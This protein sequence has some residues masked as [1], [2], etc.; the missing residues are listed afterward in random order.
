[1]RVLYIDYN[2]YGKNDIVKA[3]Q[4]LGYETEITD[5]PLVYGE[6]TE[7]TDNAVF[8]KIRNGSYDMV[9][10]SNYYPAVSDSCER[11]GVT[12][13][14]W[15]YDS[16]RIALYDSTILNK[17]NHAFTFD[18]SECAKLRNKG[19]E[20]IYYMPLATAAER[21]DEISVTEDD[22][23][24]FGADV[25]LVASLYNE[26]HNLYDR[27]EGR[28]DG[29]TRG[30]LLGL[31]NAQMN[32]F[33]SNILEDV[34]EGS[35]PLEKMYEAMPYPIKEGSLA[36]LEYIYS[37]YF[38]CR[39]VATMQR[40]GMIK[41]ISDSF[42]MKVYTPG[43]LSAITGV[44]HMGTVDYNSDMYKVFNLSKI[45]MNITLPSIKTGIPLRAMDIM[46]AGGFL[47]TNYQAD[48]EGLFEAGVDYEYYSS[49]EE[50]LYKIEYYLGHEEEWREIAD[51]GRRRVMQSFTDYERLKDMLDIVNQRITDR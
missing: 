2:L 10:T 46:G 16:P 47:L 48:F 14:S 17:C 1:M 11:I 12:Y 24:C 32:L 25:S 18:S 5:I 33:G 34:L 26:E 20:N 19:V 37:N 6:N 13:V 40:L 39:K 41:S 27:M 28:L 15:T 30:Y 23:R 36:T 50:A 49:V 31:M 22:R 51:N 38:L 44:K 4:K 8:D 21:I 35:V 29:Y 3:F 43:D 7:Q 45:N 42:E 9:F